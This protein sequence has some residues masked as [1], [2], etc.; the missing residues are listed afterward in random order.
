MPVINGLKNR[1]NEPVPIK[2]SEWLLKIS[3][4]EINHN[5]KTVYYIYDDYVDPGS[6]SSIKA[7][8]GIIYI[9]S[10]GTISVDKEWLKT[11]VD[12]MPDLNADSIDGYKI[13]DTGETGIALIN[14][15][16]ETHIAKHIYFH[17]GAVIGHLYVCD[18]GSIGSQYG[19]T[20]NIHG[21]ADKAIADQSGNNIKGTYVKSIN[22]EN[23]N[24][25]YTYGDD[26]TATAPL[27]AGTAYTGGVGITVDGSTITNT[28]VTS[29]AESSI[30]GFMQFTVNGAVQTVK[31]HGID[32]AAYRP[33]S[34]FAIATHNHDTAYAARMH[35]HDTQYAPY[36]VY[37][38]GESAGG[39]AINANYASSLADTTENHKT[40]TGD[41]YH[42]LSCLRN[43]G[44]GTRAADTTTC[45]AGYLYGTH[46]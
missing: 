23:G 15:Q 44:F 29:V 19:F 5:T 7:G 37:A 2:K 35:N 33:D 20:G 38:G 11:T 30:N 12:S 10:T 42:Y 18:D 22:V 13:S 8:E 46:T 28:G 25:V 27:P 21:T 39:P 36:G 43:I 9:A 40:S 6:G 3:T 41:S 26:H 14:D 16:G 34:Y 24:I 45:P 1:N 31:V 4:G 17:D 32:S